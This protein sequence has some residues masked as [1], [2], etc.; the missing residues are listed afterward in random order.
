[1]FYG[2]S[3]L[4][5]LDLS[6]FNLKNTLIAESFF[7]GCEKLEQINAPINLTVD[8]ALPTPL[9]SN[10][11][12]NQL[13]WF[14]TK[15]DDK[16]TNLPTQLTD[17]I[18]LLK[19]NKE[20]GKNITLT[21]D[22]TGYGSELNLNVIGSKNN[23]FQYTYDIKFYYNDTQTNS[24]SQLYFYGQEYNTTSSIDVSDIYGGKV[25]GDVIVYVKAFKDGYEAATSNPV[26]IRIASTRLEPVKNLSVNGKIVSW[27]A[28]SGADRYNV[29][30]YKKNGNGFYMISG[31]NFTN[32]M[33]TSFDFSS[34]SGVDFISVRALSDNCANNL[35]SDFTRIDITSSEQTETKYTITYSLN[36]GK[37]SSSNPTSYTKTTASITLK[38][39]TKTGYTF[40]GWYSDSKYTKKVTTIPTGST[41]NKTFYAKWNA[42]TYKLVFRGNGSN[43]GSLANLSCNYGSTYT[44]RANAFKR[45]GYT[46]V[47]WNTKSNGTGT[48]YRDKAK[49]KNLTTSKGKTITLYAQWK[50][51]KYTIKY[52]LNGGKNNKKNPTSYTVATANI[53]LQNPTKTGYTFKGWY[54]DKKC[55]KKVTTIKKGST[56]T[57]NLYAKWEAVNY[58]IKYN[59]NGGKNNSKNPKKYTIATANIKLQTPTKTGYTFKGWYS[60]KKCTKK[61][62]TIKKGSTGNKILYAKWIKK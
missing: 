15:T 27:N 12:L 50:P 2:C 21:L 56:G 55:T 46:F 25:S 34:Y 14:N 19:R 36:G 9:Y 28:V 16:C 6:N 3:N 10:D 42:N 45:T 8:I 54:S 39:P 1:M 44:L 43:S 7:E 47:G 17:S 18:V 30:L 49:V 20:P 37:N 62:T 26:T 57:V 13:Y 53:K 40:G 32:V 35:H 59:L 5:S 61:V 58:S 23:N 48:T 22:S 51:V 60:D 11:P 52:N 4:T 24:Y 31:C 38:N 41:G 29:Q 33:G